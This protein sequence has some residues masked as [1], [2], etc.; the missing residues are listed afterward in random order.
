MAE[1][2]VKLLSRPGSLLAHHSSFLTPSAAT[3]FQGEPLW[4]AAKFTG[5]GKFATYD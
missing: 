1:D 2:I 5:V 4:H 3:Q